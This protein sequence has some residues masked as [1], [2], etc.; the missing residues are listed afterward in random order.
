MKTLVVSEWAPPLVG[1]GPTILRSLLWHF[2]VGSYCILTGSLLRND[3]RLDPDSVLDCKYYWADAHRALLIRRNVWYMSP[4][5]ELIVI[6]WVTLKGLFIVRKE[7]VKNILATTYG[8]FEV[9]AYLVHKISRRRLFLYLFDI[10]QESQITRWGR[11]KSRLM[12][13][14]LIYSARKVFVMSEFLKEHIE[15]KYGI[16]PVFIP[17]PIDTSFT[18]NNDIE[19]LPVREGKPFTVVYTGMIYHAQVDGILNMVKVVNSMDDGE[20]VFRVYS[21]QSIESL[22]RKGIKG[23]NVFCGFVPSKDIPFVQQEA[24]VLFISYSFN[25]RYPLV[26][27]TASPGKIAEYLA[28]GRPIIVNAPGDSYISYYARAKGFGI[29]VDKNDHS[30]LKEAVLRL[31]NDGALCCQLVDNARKTAHDHN[32]KILSERLQTYFR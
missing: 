22:E 31:M 21:P 12:E 6:L 2:P 20:V 29:V 23:H 27:K 16:E 32:G 9:A 10:Y 18:Y 1:G 11:F 24:D 26:I 5:I 17:H 7:G 14:L 25:T 15:R 19:K 28:A 13:P 4:F 30:Q 8:G 3:R